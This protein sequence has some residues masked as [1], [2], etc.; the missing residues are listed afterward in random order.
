MVWKAPTA[1]FI[2]C[3]VGVSASEVKRA[4]APAPNAMQEMP[5]ADLLFI[6]SADQVSVNNVESPFVIHALAWCVGNPIDVLLCRQSL[7]MPTG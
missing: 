2:A 3:Y 6:L 1:I 4:P 7:L 5:V